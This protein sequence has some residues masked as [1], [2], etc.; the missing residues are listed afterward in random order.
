MAR[1]KDIEAPPE[2]DRFLDAPH[3]RETL[4]IFG[5]DRAQTQILDAYRAGRLPQ[6]WIIGGDIGLAICPFRFGQ[7]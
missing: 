4:K 5:H 3:P 1:A 2:S 7:S 6:A